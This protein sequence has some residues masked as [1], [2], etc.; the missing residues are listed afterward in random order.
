MD[1]QGATQT[2]FPWAEYQ[3]ELVA[4]QS[5]APRFIDE[6]DLETMPDGSSY[7]ASRSFR[8]F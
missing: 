1:L 6:T 7:R 5:E 8:V 2:A 3:P 4:V